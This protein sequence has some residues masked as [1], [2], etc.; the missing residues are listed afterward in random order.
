MAVA[1]RTTPGLGAARLAPAGE[2]AGGALVRRL[3]DACGF[4]VPIVVLSADPRSLAEAREAQASDYLPKPFDMPTCS[5][6]S[7][8]TARRRVER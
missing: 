4:S 8:R 6:W 3:R 2:P 7:T 1:T 5:T